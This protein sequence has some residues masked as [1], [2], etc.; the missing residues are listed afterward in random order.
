MYNQSL[1]ASL[2]DNL[3]EAKTEIWAKKLVS[4]FAKAS[5]NDRSQIMAVANGSRSCCGK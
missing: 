1:V 3:G 5:R 2:I 4:N